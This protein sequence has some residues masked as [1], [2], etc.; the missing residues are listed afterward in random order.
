MI[1]MQQ[2]W[3]EFERTKLARETKRG[4]REVSEQGFRAGGR[5]PYGY[6]R[7]LE[8]MPESHKGNRDKS[9]V[10]LVP[11]QDQALVVAEIFDLFVGKKMNPKA[12]ANHLNQ[13]GGPPS[14][15]H[16]DSSRNVRGHWAASTIRAMLKNPVY[17]GRIVWNR[18][19]FTDAKQSG[20]GAR[21]RAKEE[22]VVTEEAHLPLV[23]DETYEAAQA[24]FK[25]PNR[26]APSSRAKR[27]YIFAGM[28]RCCAGHQ[29]LSMAGKTRKGHQYYVCGYAA[30]Y[31]DEAALESHGGQK[32]I[33]IR[34][35]ALEEHVLRFF[36]QRIFGPMRIEKLAKQL[37]AHSR[38]E[39]CKGK[40][41]GTRIREQVAEVDR[42]I[43]AQVIALEE[44]VEMDLVSERIGELRAQKEALEAALA[45]IGEPRQEDE[46]EELM[47][48]L[49]ELPD[50]TENL[51][52]ASPQIKRQ[53]FQAF[54][55]QIT[56]DK[57]ECR[58]E[59][60]ATVS[61]A[62]AK[63]FN[64]K[65]PLAREGLAVVPKDIA[66]AGFEPATF[67]L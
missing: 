19:D 13:P 54:D 7:N 23:S 1:G 59:I 5:A 50:L 12:I 38:E 6:R 39:K 8:A 2:L 52:N 66:G 21:Q 16:V 55:L 15:S 17:T 34:E 42:K 4:M 61:E 64:T 48:R 36:A 53:V 62:V 3:D 65:D 18:L 22:W 41:T 11:D 43:K 40:L 60:S 49:E 46:E 57:R 28:I 14:P 24:R 32:W 20:G 63:S 26:S 10:T 37:R 47:K 31:G 29:P 35:D 58:V 25:S 27:D 45:E 51:R 56:F 9:R 67:G 44:G 30:N 33:S